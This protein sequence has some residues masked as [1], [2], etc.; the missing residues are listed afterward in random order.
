MIIV[1][2][3]FVEN[4]HLEMFKRVSRF[5]DTFPRLPEEKRWLIELSCV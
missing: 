3:Q 2:Y 5:P 4:D 1:R